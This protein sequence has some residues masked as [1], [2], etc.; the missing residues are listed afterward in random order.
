VA[1]VE[2]ADHVAEM[3]ELDRSARAILQVHLRAG[4][5]RRRIAVVKKRPA[6]QASLYTLIQIFSVTSSKKCRCPKHF[7]ETKTTFELNLF[8]L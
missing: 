7:F 6:L 3:I 2:I 4:R 5:R 8:S 1:D